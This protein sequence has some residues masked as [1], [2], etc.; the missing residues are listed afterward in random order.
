LLDYTY[1][2]SVGAGDNGNVIGITNKGFSNRSQSFTYDTLNRVT[3]G[4][5]RTLPRGTGVNPGTIETRG[6]GG[7]R[8]LPRGTGLNP[9][10]IETRGGAESFLR[11]MQ[12]RFGV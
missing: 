1:N 10:T 3:S 4:G 8:T 12:K 7:W 5:W 6:V 11:F 9:C 2:F